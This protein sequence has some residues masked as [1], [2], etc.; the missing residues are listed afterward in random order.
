MH[1]KLAKLARRQ[2]GA[3]S[4]AQALDF[5]SKTTVNRRADDGQWQVLLPGV[6]RVAAAPETRLMQVHAAVLYAG[7]GAVASRQTAA[8]IFRI[9]ADPEDDVFITVPHGRRVWDQLG[10]RVDRSRQLSGAHVT[11]RRGVPVTSATRTIV[12]LS[13]VLPRPAL[14]AAIADA[15]R[16]GLLT[17]DYLRRLDARLAGRRGPNV[18]REVLADF[19]PEMESI[20]EREYAAL[21]TAAGM[22][23]GKP[24]H[25][26][27]DGP[28]LVARVDFAYV[29]LRLAV[30][31]DGYTY[32]SQREQMDRDR[33]RDRA[34][35]RRRWDVLRFTTTDIR[36]DPAGVVADL[37]DRL[38][39]CAA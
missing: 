22:P 17:L 9:D 24:Q 25:E 21:V 8:S 20:L 29:D 27:K 32:H 12:D 38:R 4:R 18:L 2:A 14:D 10:V 31:V 23:L 34:L 13:R 37:T 36:E 7:A 16:N 26:V 6:Y 1:A 35:A 15:V 39:A 28:L 30:E 11:T 19:D 3:F 33:R 5:Y